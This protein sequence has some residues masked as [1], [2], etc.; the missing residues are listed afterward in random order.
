MVENFVDYLIRTESLEEEYR[1]QSI[2]GLTLII[3]KV[4]AYS[5]LFCFILLIGKVTEGLIFLAAF[6]FLRQTTGGFHAKSVPGCLIGST[7]TVFAALQ[8]SPVLM[9]EH[10]IL[11]AVLL[12]LSSLCIL[13][14]APINHPNL[15]LSKEEKKH[16]RFKGKLRLCAELGIVAMGYL[17]H[18]RWQQYIMISIIICA[19]FI[20]LSKLIRQEV[21]EDEDR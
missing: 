18:M 1:D 8:I 12:F 14:F 7:L 21:L 17:L 9:Q 15:M 20:L 2:Y 6:I 10:E 19:V 16:L 11:F 3:E 4:V 13:V 5:V